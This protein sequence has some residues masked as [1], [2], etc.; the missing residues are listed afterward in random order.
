MSHRFACTR[1]A[2]LLVTSRQWVLLDATGQQL[3]GIAR[4][5][6]K[7]LEGRHKPIYSNVMD[8]GDHVVVINTKQL[9]VPDKKV[10]W[11]YSGYAQGHRHVY[12]KDFH[13]F[14][15]TECL[16]LQVELKL[17]EKHALQ[18]RLARLHLFP[19]HNYPYAANI[20]K[21]MEGPDNVFKSLTEYSGEERDMFVKA[22]DCRVKKATPLYD[23]D[24]LS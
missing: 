9:V 14:R 13:I 8:A 11:W 6:C 5:V 1:N 3:E 15:P 20:S 18:E 16:R 17:P 24:D 4:T 21:V 10:L 22:P 19:G 23:W 12:S 7:L 2:K